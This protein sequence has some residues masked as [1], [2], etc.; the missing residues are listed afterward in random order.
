MHKILFFSVLCVASLAF[1]ETVAGVKW[2]APAGWKSEAARPMRAATYTVAATDGDS[3]AAECVVF[4]FGPGQGG[5]V[6]ANVERWQGQFQGSPGKVA[7]R[8]IRGFALTTVDVSGD[9][10]GMGGA[11]KKGYRMVGAIVENPGGNLFIKFTG[12]AKTVARNLPKYEALLTS[13]SKQ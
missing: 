9:Y 8:T 11:T 13:I 3:E 7:K 12:P 5:S 2:T 6:Q 10:A 4:F 1:S